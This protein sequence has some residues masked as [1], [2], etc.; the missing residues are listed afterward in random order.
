MAHHIDPECN[1]AMIRL[2]DVLC[3]WERNTGKRSTLIFV[4]HTPDEHIVLAQ[5]GKPL[6]VSPG[7]GP[8]EILD[9]AL[10]ERGQ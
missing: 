4:P 3:T 2:L 1:K 8:K 5:D 7:M 6:S 10:R 9:I